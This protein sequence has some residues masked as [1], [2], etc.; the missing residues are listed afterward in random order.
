MD[1][2]QQA[3]IAFL[4]DPRSH[5]GAPVEVIR[6]HISHVFL[7]GDR[8]FKLKRAVRYPY[9][10]FSTIERRHAA[11]RAELA[12]NRRTAPQLYLSVAPILRTPAGALAIGAEHAVGDVLDWVVI[13]RR[14]PQDALL[15]AVAAR[16]ALSQQIVTDLAR[17]IAAFHA[18]ADIDRTQGDAA[19]VARVIDINDSSLRA[20]GVF[21]PR[22]IDRLAQDTRAMLAR[23]GALL[24]Q[25]RA[26]GKV[27]R[28]HGD[29]H[30]GNVCLLD[31]AP[32]PFDCLEFDETLA[33]IDVLYDLA[34]LLMDLWRRG[35]TALANVVFNRYLDET[36]DEGGLAALPLFLSLRASV[37]AHVTAIAS[38]QHGDPVARDRDQAAAR[39]YL[40]LA[41]TFLVPGRPLLTAI[42]GLSGTGKSSVAAALAPDLLPAPGARIVSS[43]RIRKRLFGLKA[44]DRLPSEAYA[45]ASGQ[46]VYGD[47][48]EVVRRT[49]AAGHKA[50]ADAVFARESERAAI[51]QVADDLA[52]P[53]CGF[54][55]SAPQTV[56]E[57]R[58]AARQADASDADVAVVRL[59]RGYDL[60]A[61]T[62][63]MVAADRSVAAV[64]A[65]LRAA[66]DAALSATS[67]PARS[68]AATNRA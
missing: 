27:R 35:L 68:C 6:T 62:W 46:R 42:G 39:A 10:D 26:E 55:L 43:D 56:Q 16:G 36:D 65:E 47:Q 44:E 53:F 40:D 51:A 67:A 9:V 60:G 31:G 45:A 34:F 57:Q 32:V 19:S 5:D 61:I 25:R 50:I 52:A 24:D 14:F 29:L 4:A 33:R 20:S 15:D 37:R 41:Q 13:M 12:L 48:R 2:A 11:C 30:L 63:R 66:I 18:D 49:L 7:A 59:Q 17:S 54:W 38:L 23:V 58:V 3:I 21:A 64:A 1:N 22:D 8:A 28:C